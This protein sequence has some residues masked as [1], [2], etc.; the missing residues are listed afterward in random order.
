MFNLARSEVQLNYLEKSILIRE[1]TDK[2][3]NREFICQSPE[4]RGELTN[5]LPDVGGQFIIS[6]FPNQ[7]RLFYKPTV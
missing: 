7:N 3:P 2:F 5:K 6:K 1:F 4:E